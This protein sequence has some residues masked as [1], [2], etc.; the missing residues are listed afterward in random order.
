[1]GK[2]VSYTMGP[3][4]RALAVTA[5]IFSGPR[6]AAKYRNRAGSVGTDVSIGGG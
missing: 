1:M 3:A 5:R 6:L 2:P 4:M